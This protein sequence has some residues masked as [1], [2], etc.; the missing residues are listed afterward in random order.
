MQRIG[1][2]E[3]EENMDV[4]INDKKLKEVKEFKYL[5]SMI[6]SQ[7]GCEKEIKTRIGMAK[8]AFERNRKLLTAKT[9]DLRLRVRLARCLVWSVALYGSETRTMKKKEAQEIEAL[10]MWIWRRMLNVSWREKRTN[11]SVLTRDWSR[12]RDAENDSEKAKELDWPCD[13]G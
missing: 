3:K 13:E 10:E 12:E 7:G 2:K 1:N 6:T 5:G 4:K 8:T 9:M 11:K